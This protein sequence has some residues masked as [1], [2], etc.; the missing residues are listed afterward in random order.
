MYNNSNRLKDEVSISNYIGEINVANVFQSHSLN[1]TNLNKRNM[2]HPNDTRSKSHERKKRQN[3]R[4]FRRKCNMV[5]AC[6]L[7]T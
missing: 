7:S 3:N 2:S 4:C 1:S 6:L 5:R